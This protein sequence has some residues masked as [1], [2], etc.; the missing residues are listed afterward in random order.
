MALEG[1]IRY[2]TA[3]DVLVHNAEDIDVT[4]IKVT[5]FQCDGTRLA[6]LGFPG[7]VIVL[8]LKRDGAIMIPRGDTV[9]QIQDRLGLIGRPDSIAEATMLLKR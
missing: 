1:A 9:L 7:D 3:F 2:P 8:S 5:N 6:E 4:E